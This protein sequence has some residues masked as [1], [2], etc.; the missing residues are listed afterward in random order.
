MLPILLQI[1]NQEHQASFETS[2]N[3]IIAGNKSIDEY[4]SVIA[5]AKKNLY[6]EILEIYNDA[7]QRYLKNIEANK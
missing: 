5:E 4:D 3:E 2:V 1:K 6:D 7:Y